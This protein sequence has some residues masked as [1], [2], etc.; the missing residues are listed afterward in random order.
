MYSGIIH[1]AIAD[2]KAAYI[3]DR[4]LKALDFSSQISADKGD[5]DKGG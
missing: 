4:D 2:C 1:V 5:Y 3:S